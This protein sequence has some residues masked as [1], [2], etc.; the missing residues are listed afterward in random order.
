MFYSDGYVLNCV[1][2]KSYIEVLAPS[3]W[4]ETLFGN[5]VQV[6]TPVPSD[7]CWGG[8][9]IHRHKEGA[10]WRPERCQKL[11][12]AGRPGADP[13]LGLQRERGL[14]TP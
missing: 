10:T 14:P 13:P 9:W 1:T 5:M 3:P 11:P 7:W 4:N 6:R 8:M 2:P 12:E